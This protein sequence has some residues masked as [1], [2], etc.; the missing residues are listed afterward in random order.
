MIELIFGGESIKN[1]NDWRS[2]LKK[3]IGGGVIIFSL[4]SIPDEYRDADS[5]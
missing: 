2:H 3:L 1:K 4:L 5:V